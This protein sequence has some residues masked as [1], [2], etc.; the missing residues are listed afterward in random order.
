MKSESEWPPFRRRR[1]DGWH[2]AS[3]T[4]VIHRLGSDANRGRRESCDRP[5]IEGADDLL[6]VVV[7]VQIDRM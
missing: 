5:L 4:E 7:L 2:I 1:L 6:V 3:L